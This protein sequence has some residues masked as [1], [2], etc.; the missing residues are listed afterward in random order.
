MILNFSVEPYEYLA[1]DLNSD[2]TI[3]RHRKIPFLVPHLN[4][5]ILDQDVDK[6]EEDK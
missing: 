1:K 6:D 3:F 4:L 2:K 5:G